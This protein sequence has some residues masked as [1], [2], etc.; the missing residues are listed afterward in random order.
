MKLFLLRHEQINNETEFYTELT[1][2][3]KENSKNKV[4]ILE[5]MNIDKIF[6]SPFIR[7][8]QTIEPYCL[9]NGKSVNIDCSLGEYPYNETKKRMS[10]PVEFIELF[11]IDYVPVLS[12]MPLY[13]ILKDLKERVKEFCSRLLLKYYDKNVNILI[14]SHKSVINTIKY[15]VTN[16]KGQLNIQEDFSMGK[17]SDNVLKK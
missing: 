6:C 14:V 4:E 10:H 8:I 16:S 12:R 7:C 13:E 15:L 17:I 2:K 11:N 3:G 1:E 5:K 9:K